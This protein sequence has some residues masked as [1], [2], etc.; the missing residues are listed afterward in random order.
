[1]AVLQWTL[2]LLL[3]AFVVHLLIWRLHKPRSAL[4]ALL[5]VFAGVGAAGLAALYFG[6]SAIGSIG[7]A[8]LSGPAAYL[9]VLIAYSSMALA[10]TICYTLIEWDS[11]TLTIVTMIGRTGKDG[12][13]EAQIL[14]FADDFPF[15]QSR[16][17][18][19]IAGGVLVKKDGRYL[20]SP[21]RH[22]FYRSILFYHRLLKT[23]QRG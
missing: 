5:V 19:L 6:D 7:L 2:V 1:M 12:L 11:P 16:I 22:I 14:K 20:A 4:K 23:T 17:E 18:S 15:V 3:A 21:G 9:H 8:R 10:Y 13:E